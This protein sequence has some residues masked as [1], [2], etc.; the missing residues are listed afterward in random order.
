MRQATETRPLM[1]PMGLQ[2]MINK[3]VLGLAAFAANVAHGPSA[4]RRPIR[5]DVF[6]VL[7]QVARRRV[8]PAAVAANGLSIVHLGAQRRVQTRQ[9]IVIIHLPLGYRQSYNQAHFFF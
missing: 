3:I 2:L 8:T 5:V 4:G 7:P 1:D 6:H 9:T